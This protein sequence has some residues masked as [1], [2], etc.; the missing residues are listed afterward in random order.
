MKRIISIVLVC[1][2]ILTLIVPASAAEQQTATGRF[3][4][5]KVGAYY[6]D[7]VY[8]AVSSGITQGTDQTHFSPNQVCTR[9]QVATFIWRCFGSQKPT[10]AYNPFKDVKKG[11]YYYDAVLWCVEKGITFGTS[12]DSFSPKQYCTR[13][14]VAVFLFRMHAYRK[15]WDNS[16]F[17]FF[18]G[19][20][21]RWVEQNPSVRFEDV[22][23]SNYYGH[24]V[25]AAELWGVAKGVN[26][27]PHLF[28]PNRSCT[29]AEVITML[30][31]YWHSE[32]V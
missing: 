16:S 18:S 32:W 3:E 5:V 27:V 29:R 30:Y 17:K 10:T 22:S 13:G 20:L 1:L 31:R 26:D 2:T 28:M 12:W 8:W 4:D 24:A 21:E 25:Y 11:D 6:Y 23:F 14:Q 9:A 15:N 7:A 19:L